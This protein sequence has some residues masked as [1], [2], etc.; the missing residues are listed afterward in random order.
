MYHYD[1]TATIQR[2]LAEGG[3]NISLSDIGWPDDI[4]DQ[5]NDLDTAMDA[6]FVLYCIAIATSGLAMIGALIVFLIWGSRLLSFGNWGLA[7]VSRMLASPFPSSSDPHFPNL[8][9]HD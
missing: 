5:I 9:S 7:T 2:E 8:S 6:S 1:P 3:L 4:Q